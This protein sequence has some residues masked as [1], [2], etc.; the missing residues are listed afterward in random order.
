[1]AS[2]ETRQKGGKTTKKKIGVAVLTG[3]IIFSICLSSQEQ[4][5]IAK[6]QGGGIKFVQGPTNPP[7][8]AS[9]NASYALMVNGTYQAYFKSNS[10]TTKAVHFVNKGYS[11]DMDISTSQ[12]HWYNS[13]YNAIIGMVAEMNPQNTVISS[14][15]STITYQNAWINTDLKYQ[16]YSDSLKETLII[17]GISPPSSA[18]KPDYLQYVSNCYFNNSL[19]IYANGIGYLHPTNQKFTTNGTISFNDVNNATIFYLP[20]PV[21]EDSGGNHT[22]G[23][24]AV[25]ANNGILIINIR[26][27]KTFIDHAV[28][29]VYLDPTVR[30][31]GNARG[32][33]TSS[34]LSVVLASAPSVGNLLVLCFGGSGSSDN[35]T[36][37]SSITD[38][39][40][41]WSQVATVQYDGQGGYTAN[42]EIWVGVVSAGAQDTYS[43]AFSG[44]VFGA[45]ADICEYSGLLTADYLDQTATNQG[46]SA[47]T[48]TGTTIA[49]TQADELWV[50][51]TFA[52]G[53]NNAAPQ[54]T[55]TNSFT[56][57]DGEA[58][59]ANTCSLAYLEKIVSS[60]GAANSGTTITNGAEQWA[61]CIVTLK[62]SAG[63]SISPTYS[64]LSSSSTVAGASCQFNSTWT[65][66]TDLATTGG[67]IFGT[68]NTGTFTNET[69]A[70]F[71]SNPE[72]VSATKILNLTIGNKVQWQVWANDTS[73]NW[74]NTGLQNVT[75]TQ[76]TYTVTITKDQEIILQGY[77]VNFVVHP[78]RDSVTIDNVVLNVTKDGALFV[79][80]V[81]TRAF[82][83]TE[84][85]FQGHT[86]NISGLYDNEYGYSVSFTATALDVVWQ[87]PS[88]SSS[89]TE[90][91]GTIPEDTTPTASNAES[92][93]FPWTGEQIAAGVIIV[94]VAVVIAVS[95]S[96]KSSSPHRKRNGAI[97][98]G[99]K[100]KR[101]P[102]L[103]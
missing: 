38:T 83:D 94:C 82:S 77:L 34:P 11:F 103:P 87:T 46:N 22:L 32:A 95:V 20:S 100:Q 48:D 75:L 57:L 93:K 101:E 72:T 102:I 61:G 64:S 45:I 4:F 81:T 97:L 42:T 15:G 31:Q 40:V 36:I 55:P 78:V 91:N 1:M 73:N 24:Y 86:Y 2:S 66:E 12:L 7:I 79:Q 71:T 30:V 89:G 19:T 23:T 56:L 41:V 85:N 51:S 76:A 35:H 90:P 49:T 74:N 13:S 88:G 44:T 84:L 9:N 67:Y 10:M 14:S 62:A 16:A 92:L 70:A 5:F 28:F 25:T 68:N 33:N 52:V 53:Y 43:V 17:K 37:I 6:A 50:G 60:T 3:L 69:W 98:Q 8:V 18:I 54:T 63:D 99:K 27:S 47:S 58:D 80:N 21:I 39:N 65:D 26:V 29:P 59:G 96:S